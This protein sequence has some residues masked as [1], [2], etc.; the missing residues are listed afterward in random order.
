MRT[1]PCKQPAATGIEVPWDEL[2]KSTEPGLQALR[3]KLLD[4]KAALDAVAPD[5]ALVACTPEGYRYA[6]LG[7]V[8]DNTLDFLDYQR[9][10]SGGQPDR[11]RLARRDVQVVPETALS[12]A[13]FW[14]HPDNTYHAASGGNDPRATARSGYLVVGYPAPIATAEDLKRIGS[15]VGLKHIVVVKERADSTATEVKAEAFL[16]S[17]S[18]VKVVCGFAVG[19]AGKLAGSAEEQWVERTYEVKTGRTVSSREFTTGGYYTTDATW[20]AARAF[21]DTA[22][23]TLG[24]TPTRCYEDRDCGRFAGARCRDGGCRIDADAD[25]REQAEADVGYLRAK[26][27]FEATRE[28]D[29]ECHALALAAKTPA[30]HERGSPYFGCLE[31]LWSELDKRAKPLG[32]TREQY[33]PYRTRWTHEN[34]TN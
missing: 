15:V 3:K 7:P 29:A 9:L 22:W 30:D 32:L 17:L 23:K 4:V 11:E 6:P 20:D 28:L 34:G 33:S 14:M 8:A 19:A 21:E 1:T 31:R 27:M 26:P 13:L 5:A 24:V 12:Q 25:A 16:V 18:P 2:K 10:A